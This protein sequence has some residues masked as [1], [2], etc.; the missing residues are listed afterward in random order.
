MIYHFQPV[1]QMRQTPWGSKLPVNIVWLA[2]VY[3]VIPD[4]EDELCGPPV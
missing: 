4:S 3:A 1:K 2:G